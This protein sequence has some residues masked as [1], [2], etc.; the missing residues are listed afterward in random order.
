MIEPE[1]EARI[2]QLTDD[3]QN[4][5]KIQG[6]TYDERLNRL[7]MQ[8][9]QILSALGVGGGQPVQAPPQ[10]Q[11]QPQVVY[12]APQQGM[13]QQTYGLPPQQAQFANPF[14]PGQSVFYDTRE[15]KG[16]SGWKLWALAGGCVVGGG[17]VGYAVHEYASAISDH[18]AQLEG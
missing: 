6:Q 12:G 17:L 10:P 16:L 15:V 2:T 13:F 8:Q 18:K 4:A 7:F 5:L 11:G 9:Q 3:L 14:M 1:V